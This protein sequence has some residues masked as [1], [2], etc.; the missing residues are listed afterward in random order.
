M[1]RVITVTVSL[2]LL[3]RAET[4][5]G[6]PT[7]E[8]SYLPPFAS[9]D[10]LTGVVESVSFSNHNVVAYI[11]VSAWWVKP[12]TAAPLT[13]IASNGIFSV[14]ITTGGID[15]CATRVALFVIT[16]GYAPPLATGWATL[17]PE[18]FS[19]AV[20]QVQ[21]DR[22]YRRQIDFS[23]YKWRVKTSC[24]A[25]VGPGSNYFSDSANNVWVDPAGR[26]HLGI[27]QTTGKWECA[28][29]ISEKSFGYGTYRF[30]VDSNIDALDTNA[31]LGLFTWD[32]DPAFTHREIDFEASRWSNA[33]DTNNAQ[34]VVQPFG[35]PGHLQRFRVE[36]VHSTSTHV[37]AWSTGNVD[38]AS[39]AGTYTPPAASNDLIA[40]WNFAGPAVPPPG[41]EHARMN[42]WLFNAADPADGT[43]VEVIISQFTFIP[44]P[45]PPPTITAISH[46]SNTT[47]L[48]I[49]GHRDVLYR[50]D[51]STRFTNWTSAGSLVATQTQFDIELTTTGT[52]TRQ[53]QQVV[54]PEQQ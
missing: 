24:G 33:T 31:V 3:I 18:L 46:T 27:V 40:T 10:N 5:V 12:T 2:L 45:I 25:R 39:Y 51:T 47:H 43:N 35:S 1:H 23:G 36:P 41:N 6:T 20:A 14:D 26:L 44:D 30:T 42:L 28:E 37:F 38:F 54:A 32:D 9:F 52:V 49:S 17:P 22:P 34:F 7:I 48:G 15:Q 16:N 53:F 4:S 21:V 8:V 13:G 50:V 19:N 29:I 11:F